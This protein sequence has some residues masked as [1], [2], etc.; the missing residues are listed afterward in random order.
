MVG[1]SVDGIS[2][3]NVFSAI[4]GANPYPSSEGIAELKV[5]AFNNNAEF[6]QVGDVTFTTKGG[7]NTFH[8]SLFE[9]LQNDALDA[10][11]QLAEKAPKRFNTFG[12][13]WWPAVDRIFTTDTTRRSSSSTMRGT[14]DGPRR[15]SSMRCRASRQDGRS[16]RYGG[17]VIPQAS[18]NPSLPPL[19]KYI[20]PPNLPN[21]A[22]G[23][24]TGGRSFRFHR[25]QTA[26]MPA[27]IRPLTRSS[28]CSASTGRTCW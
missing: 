17:P 28:R 26:S 23:Q 16:E 15:R 2:T 3:S 25:T 8:G 5:A 1:Y 21:V 10:H 14:A 7:T 6:S 19:N 22:V 24:P 13:Y 12:G 11:V 4:A 20:P 27:S 9:Y 18:I